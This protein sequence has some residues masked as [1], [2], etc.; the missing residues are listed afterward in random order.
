MF[1]DLAVRLCAHFREVFS[2][3]YRVAWLRRF[4]VSISLVTI[5]AFSFADVGP[6]GS[7]AADV[8]ANR[9]TAFIEGKPWSV[10]INLDG[11]KPLPILQPKTILGGEDRH[12]FIITIIVEQENAPLTPAQV[13]DKYLKPGT[14]G[15]EEG[16][17]E[18]ADIDGMAITFQRW[19]TGPSPVVK[20]N[21]YSVK[22]AMSF[23]IHISAPKDD[24]TRERILGILK[25]F[26]VGV[27][28]EAKEMLALMDLLKEYPYPDKHLAAIRN[29]SAK[30]PHNPWAQ[31]VLGDMYF[32]ATPKKIRDATIA[33]EQALENQK[34]EPLANAH[35]LWT[36]I[37][38][39]GILSG[40]NAEMEKSKLNLDKAYKLAVE[41]G[42]ENAGHSPPSISPVG[43]PRANALKRQWST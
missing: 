1:C 23:D 22:D 2:M 7:T 8:D 26:R 29:F 30:F 16:T 17:S 12:G 38:R 4:L 43:M 6:N 5:A 15:V 33:Y 18:N 32:H 25:S 24:Q 10:T 3:R 42:D 27:S 35:A 20:A 9:V 19:N 41:L 40:M 21:G 36:C 31:F 39:L 14:P 28:D 13:R 11:F 37:E 34:Y